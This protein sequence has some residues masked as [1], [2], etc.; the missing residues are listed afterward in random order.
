MSFTKSLPRP[1]PGGGRAATLS[2][3]PRPLPI[4]VISPRSHEARRVCQLRRIGPRGA[5]R[6]EASHADRARGDRGGGD[7]RGQSGHQCG[8]RDISRPHRRP[9]RDPARQRTV[10]RR[11]VPDEG[12]VRPRGGSEDRVWQP[13]LPR[14]DRA[15]G[16]ASLRALSRRGRQHP[17]PLGGARI[18]DVRHHR[19]CPLRQ[20]LHTLARGPLRRRLDGR[21]NGRGRRRHRPDRARLGHRRIAAHSGELLRRR[22]IEAVAR[23]RVVR[24]DGGRDRLRPRA[25]FR[26]GEVGA[27]R[28]GDARLPRRSRSRATRS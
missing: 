20:H 15:A 25:E 9:R 14:N 5:C 3:S 4:Q 22:R 24:P 28:R 18:F 2:Q 27:R 8:R 1:A 12:R 11:A 13:A 26:A 6:A 23:P 19:G 7:R 16:Y 21:R 17:R 10:S